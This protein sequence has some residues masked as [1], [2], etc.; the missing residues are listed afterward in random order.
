MNRTR[1]DWCDYSWNPVVGCLHG[2]PYCYAKRFAERGLGEYGKHPKGKRFEP[3]LLPERLDEPKK[4][5]TPSRIFAVSMGDLFGEWVPAEWIERVMRAVREAPQHQFYFLTKN[6]KRYWDVDWPANAWAGTSSEGG[7]EFH[8]RLEHL[9]NA[10]TDKLFVS[11]EPLL[12][13]EMKHHCHYF[14]RLAWA[15][16]GGQTGPG[17]KPPDPRCIRGIIAICR[18]ARIPLFLK[19]NLHWPEPIQQFPQAKP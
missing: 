15:I 19:D 4:V 8:H 17:A 7:P 10:K 16:V 9:L 11:L 5:R 12:S 3:R 6:P 13:D 14:F 18:E 1:I 2:C